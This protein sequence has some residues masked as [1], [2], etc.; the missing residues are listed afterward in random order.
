ME[1]YQFVRAGDQEATEMAEAR[2][3][4]LDVSRPL[5]V[6]P[7]RICAKSRIQADYH[8]NG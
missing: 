5:V 8:C 7:I 1:R 3:R 2:N 4:R 6:I